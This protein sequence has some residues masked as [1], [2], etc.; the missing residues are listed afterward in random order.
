MNNDAMVTIFGYGSLMER[1]S[2]QKTMPSAKNF[3][4]GKLMDYIRMFN[5][6]SISGIR[7]GVANIMSKEIAALSIRTK[8][9]SCVMG[10]LFDLPTEQLD[11]YLEREHRYKPIQASVWDESHNTNS[12]AWTVVEQTDAEYLINRCSNSEAEYFQRVKQYYDGSLWGR[13]DILPMPKYCITCL[14]AAYVLGGIDYINNMLDYT[15]LADNETSLRS[16]LSTLLL[17]HGAEADYHCIFNAQQDNAEPEI[18]AAI[19][20]AIN[21]IS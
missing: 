9:D 21:V 17:N 12:I 11:G 10:V 7:S 20:H 2:A 8:T 1:S 16:Y 13:N 4:R 6:V 19:L 5:L 18:N 3:R 15:M 14:T